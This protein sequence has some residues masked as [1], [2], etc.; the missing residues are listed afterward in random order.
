MALAHIEGGGD[1]PY[2]RGTRGERAST[3]ALS[4]WLGVST[5]GRCWSGCR[6]GVAASLGEGGLGGRLPI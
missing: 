5:S 1:V 3:V 4:R 2:A 6:A